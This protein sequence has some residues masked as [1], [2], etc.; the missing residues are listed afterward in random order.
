MDI[1]LIV[2]TREVGIMES[3]CLH[4]TELIFFFLTLLF[5]YGVVRRVVQAYTQNHLLH[6]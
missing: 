3:L 4:L 2:F 5:H 1:V 6:S